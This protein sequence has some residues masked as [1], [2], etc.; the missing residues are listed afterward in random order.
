MSKSF[1]FASAI[2][3]VLVV[4]APAFAADP[5][6]APSAPPRLRPDKVQVQEIRQ[7]IKTDRQ[8]LVSD[9]AKNHADRLTNRFTFYFNRLTNIITRFQA[10]L[11]LLSGQKIDTSAAQTAL[12]T[13][14]S[15]L[16]AAKTAGDQAVAAFRAIDPT[17]LST[18]HAELVAARDLAVKARKA[19]MDVNVSLKSALRALKLISKPALP[20][21][22]AAVENSS[23]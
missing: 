12:N 7:D 13:A 1:F 3:A 11:D 15:K 17:K 10:R 23:K 21:A 6:L 4:P 16:A 8:N 14:K 2:F 20:A 22:S 9:L 19:Y 18:E 5:T